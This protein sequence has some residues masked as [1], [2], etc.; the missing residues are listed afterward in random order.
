MPRAATSAT[1]LPFTKVHQP[2]Y[3]S[4]GYLDVLLGTSTTQFTVTPPTGV[5]DND[6][7]LVCWTW[8]GNNGADQI[9]NVSPTG[10]NVGGHEVNWYGNDYGNGMAWVWS[11][12]VP[13]GGWT[14]NLNTSVSTLAWMCCQY[15]NVQPTS[16]LPFTGTIYTNHNGASSITVQGASAPTVGTGNHYMINII[17]YTDA[18]SPY[19]TQ[20]SNTSTGPDTGWS[21]DKWWWQTAGGAF[22]PANY[23]P[24]VGLISAAELYNA[25]GVGSRAGSHWT[26]DTY[27]Y[28]GFHS[29][30]MSFYPYEL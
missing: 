13:S 4:S 10:W 14:F 6:I 24:R 9:T 7:L 27:M 22:D 25:S 30:G 5:S 12:G 23:T 28:Y 21:H 26:F 1:G 16:G 3:P 11:R 20:L 18:S 17:G 2:A 15:R 29:W 19:I 8:A